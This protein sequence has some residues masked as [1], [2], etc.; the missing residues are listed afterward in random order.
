MGLACKKD[1]WACTE[2][3]T[4]CQ[5]EF[6]WSCCASSLLVSGVTSR[7]LRLGS[8]PLCIAQARAAGLGLAKDQGVLVES[9]QSRHKH[10]CWQRCRCSSPELPSPIPSVSSLFYTY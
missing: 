1:F 4:H 3:M 6:A 7:D 8:L 2:Q 10:S 9:K 5:T